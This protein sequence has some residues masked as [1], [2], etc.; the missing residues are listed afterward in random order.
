MDS[1]ISK[2]KEKADKNYNPQTAKDGEE[3][4]VIIVGGGAAG[5]PAAVYSGRFGL[6]TLVVAGERGGL[7]KTTHI[8]ENYPG[9]IRL[10]GPEIMS[11]L[12]SHVKDY[13]VPIIDEWVQSLEKKGKLFIVKTDEHSFKAKTVIMATGTKH[14]KLGIRGEEELYGKGVS[15]CATCDGPLFKGKTIGVVGGSDSA[16]K[17][18][19][20][21]SEYGKVYII[22]RKETI[23]PEPINLE[24]VEK[25]IKEGKI[26]II[27]NTNVLEINGDRL[28]SHVILD[29]PYKNS[30]ELKLGG[31]FIA[32]GHVPQSH[33]AKHIG[34]KL[35][36][37]EE[38]MINKLS[39]T[40]IPGFFAAGDVVNTPWKQ[41][42]IG[43]AEGCMAAYSAYEYIGKNFKL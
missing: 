39:E 20:L 6:K 34:V 3:F 8:V 32:I 36:E 30:K 18:A 31:I 13:Q 7:L 22:Y 14:K 28:I 27:N 26:E 17:E 15:Y 43:A 42:I 11:H 33:L 9:F 38:I 24:R 16:A 12:E 1:Y 35:D 21:L 2:E 10:S 40:S 23:R 4:D 41:A 25:K 5:Y 29:K 37:K 19:L